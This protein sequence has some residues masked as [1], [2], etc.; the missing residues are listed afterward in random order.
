MDMANRLCSDFYSHYEL[1]C[2]KP[3]PHAGINHVKGAAF[4]LRFKFSNQTA[5][6]SCRLIW[7]FDMKQNFVTI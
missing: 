7:K 4:F 3:L 1:C 2:Q 6:I 5:R